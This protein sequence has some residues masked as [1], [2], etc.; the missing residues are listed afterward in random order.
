MTVRDRRVLN[1]SDLEQYKR[2]E[3]K[4]ERAAQLEVFSK[5]TTEVILIKKSYC[6]YIIS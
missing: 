1:D 2:K 5:R 3:E 4:N 6:Y